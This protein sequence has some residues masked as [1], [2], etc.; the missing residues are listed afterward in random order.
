LLTLY[1]LSQCRLPALIA[2]MAILMLFIAPDVSQTLEHRQ[3]RAAHETSSAA[4]DEMDMM[5]MDH[6][7]KHHLTGVSHDGITVS[8]GNP[9][10]HGNRSDGG[11]MD[12]FACGYCQL[13][14]HSPLLAWMLIPLIS[15]LFFITRV[16]SS[17][18]S[19]VTP[20][21]FFPGISQPRAPPAV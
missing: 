4:M 10:P 18:F 12:D 11:I 9:V 17:L 13:L 16:A 20:I 21:T 3:V 8:V 14:V 1:R 6:D 15:L 7:M 5:P 2:L 19:P